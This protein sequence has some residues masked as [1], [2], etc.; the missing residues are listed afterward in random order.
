MRVL[1]ETSELTAFCE[2]AATKPYVT[3]DTE[4]MRERTYYSRLCLLQLAYP[5]EENH[6][7]VLVDPLAKGMSLQPLFALFRNVSVIKVFH[8]A[9]QD[10]E[11][12]W[13]DSKVFPKPLFDTQVAAMVC[14]FGEQV[15]YETLVRRVCGKSLDKM[16][17]ITDWSRRPLSAT[18]KAY[19]LGDV[20]HLRT[21]YEHL[22]KELVRSG[23]EHWVAE[24]MSALTDPATY[25]VDPREAWKRIRARP[26]TGKVLAVLRELAAFREELA[27]RRNVPRNRILRDEALV[28]LASSAPRNAADIGK[29]R[30]LP[31]DARKGMVLR[32]IF[33]AI[34]TGLACPA[35]DIPSLGN[36]RD[37]A[38]PDTALAG[39]LRVLLKSRAEKSG[40]APRLIAPQADL[41]AMAA[42][43]RDIPALRGWRFEL[44]GEDALRLCAGRIALTA[45]EGQVGLVEI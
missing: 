35:E 13:L 27:Q 12:F 33:S 31:G 20:T 1:G 40:V 16:V 45:Q 26:R 37:L 10:L 41:D 2:L 19:A 38:E 29:L 4:F 25:N 15:G 30:L 24:E 17:R 36:G 7:A 44:F 32:G 5:G 28:E 22:A 8:A 43:R 9:R 34:E 3:V 14:G 18:Q 11:M 6:C 21:V 23:R 39:L 42:G